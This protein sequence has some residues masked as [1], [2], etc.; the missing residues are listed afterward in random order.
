MGGGGTS[1]GLTV[2]AVDTH[3]QVDPVL[4]VLLLFL[5]WEIRHI[6]SQ[7]GQVTVQKSINLQLFFKLFFGLIKTGERT[8]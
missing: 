3:D 8:D 7:H 1:P 6:R 4:Q 2:Q 5:W